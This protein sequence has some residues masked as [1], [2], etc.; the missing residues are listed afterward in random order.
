MGMLLS[1]LAENI[2]GTFLCY[3]AR[4]LQWSTIGRMILGNDIVRP[5]T[6]QRVV[7]SKL[8]KATA[9]RFVFLV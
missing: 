4:F 9:E 3:Q 8:N 7:L 1:A 2:I 5:D 6:V